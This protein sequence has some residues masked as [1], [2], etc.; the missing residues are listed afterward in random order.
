MDRIL[1]SEGLSPDNF[2][3]AKQADTL[4]TFYNLNNETVTGIIHDL[5]YEVPEDYIDRNLDYYLGRTSHGS[6]LS[7]VVHAYLARIIGRNELSWELYLDALRS[8]FVDIQGGTTAEGIHAGVMAG[9]IEIAHKA[10][11][12]L[13]LRG[14]EIVFEPSMPK[15][16]RKMTFSFKF[17]GERYEAVVED[18]KASLNKL[19]IN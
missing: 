8:D 4:M 16:W 6:T 17:R 9:T 1:K 7:R 10:F 13:D 2:K 11:A 15:H 14:E 18:G 5:G 19:Q 3:V 12:G